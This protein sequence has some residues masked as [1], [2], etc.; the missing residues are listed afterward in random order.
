MV[1][2]LA[3]T[4][5][6][7]QKRAR[8]VK[9]IL[10]DVDGVLTSGGITYDDQGRE[11]K[12][13]NVLDGH[14]IKMAQKLGLQVYFLTGRVSGAVE[15][16]A[17]ELGLDGLFQGVHQK[18]TFLDAF[19]EQHNLTLDEIAYLG[20]DLID[21]LVLKR[22]GLAGA[23][24]NCAQDIIRFCHLQTGRSGGSGA[25]AEFIEFILHSKKLWQQVL[26]FYEQEPPA[27]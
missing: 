11:L 23:V 2:F 24:Q 12:T 5:R 16:R 15:F 17:K 20:D 21:I 22:V 8:R 1:S 19:L 14:R 9:A 7:V 4:A 27:R 6:A 10:L 25:A 3:Q 26:D 13:F 18:G